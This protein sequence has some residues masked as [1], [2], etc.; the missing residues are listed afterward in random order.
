MKKYMCPNCG[1]H[2]ISFW[3]KLGLMGTSFYPKCK[4]CGEKYGLTS[5][6]LLFVLPLIVI[7]FCV[8]RFCTSFLIIIILTVLLVLIAEFLCCLFVPLETKK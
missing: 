8:L 5:K 6:R 7:W 2:S 1:V 3:K 4:I